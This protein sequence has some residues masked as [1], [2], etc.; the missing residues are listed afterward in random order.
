MA[1]DQKDKKLQKQDL[2]DEVEEE[3]SHF[4]L[5]LTHLKYK[6]LETAASQI[7]RKVKQLLSDN[8]KVKCSGPGRMPT[9][10]LL[11]V[12]R[13][14]PCGNGTNTYD[15]W[16]MRIHKRVFHIHCSQKI[17]Q[18]VISSI[19]SEPG[20]ILEAEDVTEED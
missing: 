1:T 11:L 18:S 7:A 10:H 12:T 9:K 5:T 16:E 4:K 20:M 17:F 8:V 13:K 15:N 14:S 6:G 19:R 2:E 3:I